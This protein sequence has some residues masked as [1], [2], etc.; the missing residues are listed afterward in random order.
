MKNTL[1]R[2]LLIIQLPAMAQLTK[3]EAFLRD[4]V[5]G[6]K[7]FSMQDSIRIS[8][9]NP[10]KGW[11]SA[12]FVCIVPK[13][14]VNADSVLAP[15]TQLLNS[16]KK[17]VGMVLEEVKVDVRQA[18][19]RGLIK[20]YQIRIEGYISSK[21]IHYRSIPEK[22][23]EEILNDPKVAGKNDRMLDY[24]NAHGFIKQEFGD[25]TAWVYLDKNATLE[26]PPYRTAVIYR[27]ETMIYAVVSRKD[28][29]NLEKLKEEQKHNTGQYYFFQKPN[30]RT[31][32]EVQD[33]IYNFIPL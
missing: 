12:S 30:E 28:Y 15:K 8:I 21:E 1:L 7:I 24:F 3:G 18:E 31:L 14:A 5:D 9:S 26:E 13:N 17:P 22:G 11:Y 6:N 4:K 27:G 23:L 19:G 10:D 20:F 32:K 2:L 16:A 29:F 33:I 25:Y